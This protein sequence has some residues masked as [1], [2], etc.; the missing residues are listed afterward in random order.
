MGRILVLFDSRSGNTAAM[1][2][3]VADGAA[4]VPDTE[5]RLL[6]VDD[7]AVDDA[8]WADGIA[9][10]SPTYVGAAS[11]RMKKYWDDISHPTWGQMDG[12]IGCAFSTSGGWGGGAEL[13]C[14]SILIMMMNVGMLTFGVTDYTGHQFT[15]HYGAVTAGK[16]R[17]EAEIEAARRLGGRLAQWVAVYVDGRTDQHPGPMK[18]RG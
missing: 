7:A 3:Y 1:A 6:S 11:W 18:G 8:L 12:K 2:Q 17:A 13:T 5:V 10:G 14:M 15:L 16:P 9:C 4:Q